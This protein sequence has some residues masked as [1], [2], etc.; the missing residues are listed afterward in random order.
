MPDPYVMMA[1]LCRSETGVPFNAGVLADYSGCT[2]DEAD[3]VIHWGLEIGI[4]VTPASTFDPPEGRG[5]ITVV[6]DRKAT[7]AHL[8]KLEKERDEHNGGDGPHRD[9]PQR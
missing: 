9:E 7:L 4:A 6:G 1:G 8:R 3:E 2:V 5:T